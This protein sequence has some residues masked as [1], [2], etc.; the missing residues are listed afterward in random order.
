MPVIR[1]SAKQ[2]RIRSGSL[3]WNWRRLKRDLQKLLATAAAEAS[4]SGQA[5]LIIAE[6]FL[7]FAD[8]DLETWF[9]LR[10]FVKIDRETCYARRLATK[11]AGL[12]GDKFER[13]FDRNIWPSH[14][15]QIV[16]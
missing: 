10:I 16:T 9:D 11:K 2:L 15:A 14:Q 4:A 3:P 8:P 13:D 6:G 1:T 5:R 7:L 12:V